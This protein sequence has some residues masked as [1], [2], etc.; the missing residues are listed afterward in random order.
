MMT[1]IYNNIPF[2]YHLPKNLE[3]SI[4]TEIRGINR[5]EV[6]LMISNISTDNVQHDTFKNIVD[7]LN[8][9]DVLVVNTSGTIKAAIPAKNKNNT[10]LQIHLSTQLKNKKWVAELREISENN[11]QRY[12]GGQPNEIIELIHGGSIRLIQPYYSN[13]NQEDHL[14]LWTIELIIEE[15]VSHYLEKFAQNIQYFNIKKNYP[16]SFY[17]TIFAKEFGSAEMP[18]AGRAF[19]QNVLD[20]LEKKGVEIIPILLHTGVASLEMN[21]KPYE[22]YFEISKKSATAINNARKKGKNIIAV[23]TTVIRAI[24]TLTSSQKITSSG[25]GWTNIFITPERGVNGIDGLITGFHEPK[26]SHLF[27]LE[28]ITKRKHLE[29]TYHEAVHH[30]YLWHEFGDLHLI[31]P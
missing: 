15:E 4:P 25:K 9:D 13:S 23:G 29:I 31:L 24:E 1:A 8:E 20:Q 22:E 28:A 10:F 5:D 6:R 19:T 30:K 11:T 17:Q 7:Y 21:E 3:C 18:S 14:Q 27:M 16:N 26:A 2:H 12:F